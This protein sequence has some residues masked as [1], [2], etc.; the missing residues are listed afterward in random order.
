MVQNIVDGKYNFTT[1]NI[2][3]SSL[4]SWLNHG[5]N[6]TAPIDNSIDTVLDMSIDDIFSGSLWTMDGTFT[7]PICHWTAEDDVSAFFSKLSSP[8]N[9][10]PG[11]SAR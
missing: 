2:I 1:E 8:K 9:G 4:T 5:F 11:A 3:Q 6:Y 10:G 7:I